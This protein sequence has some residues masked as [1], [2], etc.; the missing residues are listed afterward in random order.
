MKN[1]LSP[2]KKQY[3]KNYSRT[4]YKQIFYISLS[5]RGINDSEAALLD[6][7][8]GFASTLVSGVK[9]IA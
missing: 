1:L 5:L 4:T 9:L 6:S 8:R 3:P 2:N 7:I